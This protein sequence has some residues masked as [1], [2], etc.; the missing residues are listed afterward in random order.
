VRSVN[1]GSL[2]LTAALLP[3][4]P[5]IAVEIEAARSTVHAAFEPV[6]PPRPEIALA[7]GGSARAVARVIGHE[8]GPDD[9]ERLIELLAARPAAVNAEKLGLR[10][11]R[12]HTLLAG[13]LI[14]AEVSRLLELPFAP[15]RGGIREGAAFRLAARQL[16]A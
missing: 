5:P 16:A 2:R 4:D 6:Q 9:L 3:S 15:S 10:P 11:D 14:L 1:L 7:T 13:A 8:Y 12:A